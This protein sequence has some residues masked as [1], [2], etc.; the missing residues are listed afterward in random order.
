MKKNY[1]IDGDFDFDE[2]VIPYD[3]ENGLAWEKLQEAVTAYFEDSA[4]T[5]ISEL[6]SWCDDPEKGFV[7]TVCV[8][9]ELD[10]LIEELKLI[11]IKERSTI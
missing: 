2:N 11:E 5:G 7:V 3:D 1:K 10:G 4:E 6:E 8:D 9:P